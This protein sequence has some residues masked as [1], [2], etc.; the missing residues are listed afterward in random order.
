MQL[1]AK[2]TQLLPIQTGTGKNGIWK[3]QDLIVETEGQH[4]KKICISIWGDKI[5]EGKLQIGNFLKF[6]IIIESK[7]YNNKWYTTISAWKV[8]LL[9]SDHYNEA[10]IN[11]EASGNFKFKENFK[12]GELLER[13][14]NTQKNISFKILKHVSGFVN[15]KEF[16]KTEEGK[17]LYQELKEEEGV[18]LNIDEFGDFIQIGTSSSSTDFNTDTTETVSL[19]ARIKFKPRFPF[20]KNN[21]SEE[22]P[23]DFEKKEEGS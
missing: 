22:D 13:L 14:K 3:R 15:L 23:E 6:D 7:E 4:H 17:K 20:V 2:L 21:I 16:L 11:N 1:L 19:D 9:S 12:P 8:D 5:D 18:I 10:S